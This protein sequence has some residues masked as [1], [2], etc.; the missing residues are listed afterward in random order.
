MVGDRYNLTDRQRTAVM[1]C[2]CS[3]QAWAQ[4]KARRLKAKQVAGSE[5]HLDGYNVLTTVEAAL[6]GGVLLLGRDG[7]LRDMA[8]MHGSY[9]KVQETRPAL[10]LIGRVGQSLKVRQIIWYL[11]RP[12]SNSGRLKTILLEVA[13]EHGWCW[14]VHLVPNP[15]AVL[16]GSL[17]PIA[18][19]DSAVL[20]ACGGWLNLARLVVKRC[21]SDAKVTTLR[22]R[23]SW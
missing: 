8:S 11:D 7:C 23:C 21:V 18:S 10:A 14:E 16:I 20:D 22:G 12:V 6:G 5:L 2:A 4:R 9:R 1:R 19:A 17:Q 15:D 3:D 13:D